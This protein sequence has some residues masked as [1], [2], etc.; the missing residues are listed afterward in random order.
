[1]SISKYYPISRQQ[2]NLPSPF[3]PFPYLGWKTGYPNKLGNRKYFFWYDYVSAGSDEYQYIK[4]RQKF[5]C[6]LINFSG[7]DPVLVDITERVCD[8]VGVTDLLYGNYYPVQKIGYAEIITN[9][10][11]PGVYDLPPVTITL[12]DYLPDPI[13]TFDPPS[14]DQGIRLL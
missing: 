5:R 11:P 13:V 9:E 2:I 8:F 14:E 1:M 12:P 10:L 3:V 7:P 4:T 6:F